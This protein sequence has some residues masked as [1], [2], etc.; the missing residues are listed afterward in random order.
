MATTERMAI[1]AT[2]VIMEKIVT[3]SIMITMKIMEINKTANNLSA[4]ILNQDHSRVKLSL[5][6]EILVP[7]SMK[8]TKNVKFILANAQF[9]KL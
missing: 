9:L 4:K 7:F 2:M 5:F 1:M 6:L 8:A 3:M